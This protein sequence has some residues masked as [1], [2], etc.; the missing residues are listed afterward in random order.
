MAPAGTATGGSSAVHDDAE[1]MELGHDNL[2]R[3]RHAAGASDDRIV[4][5]AAAAGKEL[6]PPSSSVEQAFADQ[7]VPS[8]REQ[9]TV[10]AFVVGAVLSV[11]FNVILMKIDLTTGINP[12]LN[13]CASLLSYFLLRTWTRAIGCTGLLKQPFTRQE[14]TMIQTCVVSAYGIT[15]TGRI[16]NPKS[17]KPALICSCQISFLRQDRPITRLLV[18]FGFQIIYI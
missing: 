17:E 16:I 6:A 18:I 1:A 4:G 5:S 10:R 13:V 7:P 9:L 3:R 12:S 8:W 15:F 14:N 2:I 11:V